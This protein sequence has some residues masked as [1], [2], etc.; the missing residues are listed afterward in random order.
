MLNEIKRLLH[1]LRSATLQV[2]DNQCMNRYIQV[3]HVKK[4]MITTPRHAWFFCSVTV[5]QFSVTVA[6]FQPFTPVSTHNSAH[7]LAHFDSGI[8]MLAVCGEDSG[9]AT[10]LGPIACAHFGVSGSSTGSAAAAVA[11]IVGACSERYTNI[12]VAAAFDGVFASVFAFGGR[13]DGDSGRIAGNDVNCFPWDVCC[14]FCFRRGGIR[15]GG[16]DMFSDS[17]PDSACSVATDAA[18]TAAG[19]CLCTN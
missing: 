6:L 2:S 16:G 8:F 19:N 18:I 15:F 14:K 5:S 3:D 11:G 17:V 12:F 1:C 7:T 10:A 4:T 9:L 13:N